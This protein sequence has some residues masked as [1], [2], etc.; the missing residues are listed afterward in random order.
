M[1]PAWWLRSP[2]QSWQ[3]H[4]RG[5]CASVPTSGLR[6]GLVSI[7]PAPRPG[8]KG[9]PAESRPQTR[10]GFVA[11][12]DRNGNMLE[13]GQ[14]DTTAARRGFPSRPTVSEGQASRT[15]ACWE[16]GRRFKFICKHCVLILRMSSWCT[17]FWKSG[18]SCFPDPQRSSTI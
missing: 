12:K 2:P 17:L 6:P 16:G 15:C 8:S 10:R 7:T 13:W 14:P 11:A 3:W 9:V 18:R 4:R 1:L 5:N